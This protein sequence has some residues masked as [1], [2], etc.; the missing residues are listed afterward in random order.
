MKQYNIPVNEVMPHFT[1]CRKKTK[2][3]SVPFKSFCIYELTQ[4]IPLTKNTQDYISNLDKFFSQFLAFCCLLR[5]AFNLSN[6][7]AICKLI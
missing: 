4:V 5:L 3:I 6:H 2:L 7:K 1:D